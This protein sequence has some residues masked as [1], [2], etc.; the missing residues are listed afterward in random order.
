MMSA[1]PDPT[2]PARTDR[3]AARAVALALAATL[4]LSGCGGSGGPSGAARTTF[5]VFLF[6]LAGIFFINS[7]S[8]HFLE[9]PQ[10]TARLRAHLRPL[11]K[12]LYA[13]GA[14]LALPA[15]AVS[16][17][18]DYGVVEA[19]C[20]GLIIVG[21]CLALTTLC[22]KRWEETDAP[23]WLRRGIQVIYVGAICVSAIVYFAREL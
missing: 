19:V 11:C 3:P 16:L 15:L 4:V 7:N 13:I 18:V 12:W 5:V 21:L 1:A 6:F 8:T 14:G 9:H 17:M 23:L 22:L 2:P 20:I 10:F